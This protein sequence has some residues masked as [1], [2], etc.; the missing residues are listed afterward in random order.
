MPVGLAEIDDEVRP[1]DVPQLADSPLERAKGLG[2]DIAEDT[3]PSGPSSRLGVGQERRDDGRLP[4]RVSGERG[5][6]PP[7]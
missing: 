7:A 4:E 5:G 2:E 3:D 1:G 6:P